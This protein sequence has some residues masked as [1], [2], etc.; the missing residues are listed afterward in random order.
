MTSKISQHSRMT[1]VRNLDPDDAARSAYDAQGDRGA[2]TACLSWFVVD[3]FQKTGLNQICRQRRDAACA[4]PQTPGNIGAAGLSAGANVDEDLLTQT[5]RA[6]RLIRLERSAARQIGPGYGACASII[7][8]LHPSNLMLHLLMPQSG[9]APPWA[10]SLF[11][12]TSMRGGICNIIP[13]GQ[14]NY[15]DN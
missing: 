11:R 4:D 9:D 12:I 1:C 2:A 15:F 6:S 13:S 14:I 8:K 10:A 3:F 5:A 7:H